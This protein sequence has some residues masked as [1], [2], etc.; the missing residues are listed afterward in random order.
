M[1]RILRDRSSFIIA[2]DRNGFGFVVTLDW[3][4]FGFVAALDRNSLTLLGSLTIYQ[5]TVSSNQY[6]RLIKRIGE[7]RANGMPIAK[8]AKICLGWMV[9]WLRIEYQVGYMVKFSN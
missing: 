3:N 8:T 4:G 9:G 6:E 5:H 2:L 7:P 1:F